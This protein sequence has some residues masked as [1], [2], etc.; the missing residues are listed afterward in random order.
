[1]SSVEPEQDANQGNGGK[2]GVGEFVV[3]SGDSPVLFEFA[4][5]SLDEIAL[6]IQG[7]VGLARPFSVGLGRNDRRDA[8]FD[9]RLDQRVAVIAFVSQECLRIDLIEQRFGLCDIGRLARRERQRDWV[10]ERIDNGVDLGRQA[11]AGSSNGLVFAVFFGAPALCWWARTLVELID[12]YSASAS[13]VKTSRMR[14]NMP[15]SHQRR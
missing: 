10:A 14:A 2:K 8:A 13:S 1:M 7:K 4:E 15:L 9:K 6:S 3:A 12:M 5:E 11:A